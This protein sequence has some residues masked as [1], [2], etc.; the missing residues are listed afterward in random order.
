MLITLATTKSLAQVCV[1]ME[2][3][4]AVAQE[5]EDALIAIMR[6]VAGL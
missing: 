6:E 5:V 3:A 2:G 1:D 4:E